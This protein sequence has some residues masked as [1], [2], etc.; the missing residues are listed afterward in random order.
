MKLVSLLDDDNTGNFHAIET[1]VGMNEF[2]HRILALLDQQ[3]EQPENLGL[4]GD[5][6]PDLCDASA[7]LPV[8]LM[9]QPVEHC[10]GIA[11]V[12]GPF[13]KS[14][15]KPLVKLQ[16]TYSVKL[17]F[18]CVVKGIKIKITAAFRASRRLRFED[19][20]RIMSPEMPPKSFGTF[21]KRAPGFESRSG[22][23]FAT[24]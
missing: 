15:E 10:T 18:L 4:N 5:T 20:K 8:G 1:L 9:A 6:N 13:L 24:A 16:P 2:D 23:S 7:V 3:R 14:T 19:K 12:R 11:E 22:L 17:V 21:E